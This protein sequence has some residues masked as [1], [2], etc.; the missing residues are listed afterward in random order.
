MKFSAHVHT[1]ISD[2]QVIKELENLGYDAA[3]VPDTQMQWS[4]CYAVMALAAAEQYTEL[5]TLLVDDLTPVRRFAMSRIE[6]L[7]A[8]E[9]QKP[10]SQSHSRSPS[11]FCCFRRSE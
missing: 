1:R 2:W 5:Q 7:M 11:F 4:D 9:F 6:R 10:S 3:W 8:D